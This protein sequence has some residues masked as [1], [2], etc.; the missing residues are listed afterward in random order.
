MADKRPQ[1]AVTTLGLPPR[2]TSKPQASSSSPSG[3]NTLPRNYTS[4]SPPPPPQRPPPTPQRPIWR[5]SDTIRTPP[6]HINEIVADVIWENQRGSAIFG[7]PKFSAKSLLPTDYPEWSDGFGA[8]HISLQNTQCLPGWKWVS[9]WM[10]DSAGNV[11]P[12][13]WQYNFSFSL[14]NWSGTPNISHYVRRRKYVRMRERE[15]VGAIPRSPSPKS[16]NAIT[17]RNN[18]IAEEIEKADIVARLHRRKLDREKLL[19]LDQF[20]KRYP[21]KKKDAAAMAMMILTQF[22]YE[23]SRLKAA[24]ILCTFIFCQPENIENVFIPGDDETGSGSSSIPPPKPPRAPVI[25]S[26]FEKDMELAELSMG[27]SQSI[28]YQ[29]YRDDFGT[30]LERLAVTERR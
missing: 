15:N 4:P 22:D 14:P 6:A 23:Y 25:T 9:D 11:D 16:P 27:I 20:L 10:V 7:A 13:G 12:D 17:I 5:T 1:R 29:G 28:L 26:E 2:S 30:F 19:E 18:A 24:K 8:Y 21:S 3:P